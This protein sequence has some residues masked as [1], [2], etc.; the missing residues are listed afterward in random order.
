MNQ[1]KS[2]YF[3][4]DGTPKLRF[5]Y[6]TFMD[7]LGFSTMCDEA[8]K[9][10][11]G[12]ALLA[13]IHRIITSQVKYFQPYSGV[14]PDWY[15]KLFTDNVVS[16]YIISSQDGESELGF[17]FLH[18]IYYQ[19]ELALEGYFVRGGITTGDL[20]IDDNIVFG[21]ALIESYSIEQ[22]IARYPRIVL[23]ESVYKLAISQLSSYGDKHYSPQY[24]HIL[25]DSDG[26]PFLNY[27]EP[28]FD[29]S[30]I[31]DDSISNQILKSIKKIL[32]SWQNINGYRITT[33]LFV[34]NT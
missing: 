16:G 19:L 23:S 5:S 20:F 14:I 34:E 15:V 12:D 10:G 4:P 25:I 11:Q 21:P 26:K 1:I 3:D 9:L 2:E 17:A 33:I 22:T 24:S 7:I 18:A 32:S 31:E 13:N 8:D 29:D 28:I 30:T 27:L 6:C